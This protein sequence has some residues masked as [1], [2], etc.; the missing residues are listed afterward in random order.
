[1]RSDT[2]LR[3]AAPLRPLAVLIAMLSAS[4]ALAANN[5]DAVL[6]PVTV[7]GATPGE[8]S[9]ESSREYTVRRSPSATRLDLSLRETPQTVSVITRQ[10][11]EDFGLDSV[12][13]ALAMSSGVVV[14]KVETNRT[15]YTARGFDITNFQI[16]GV[17][18]PFVYGNVN[19]DID[20]A[21]YDR[22]DAVYGANSLMSA[23]GFPS[24]TIN[25][26]RKR[27]TPGFAAS[28]SL[29]AGS[30][31]RYRLD[32]DVSAPLN[33]AGTLRGRFVA[34]KEDANSYLD[35]YEHDKTVLYGILEADLAPSTT[36]TLGHHHQRNDA[37]SP[38]WGALPLTY[39]DGTQTDYQ[40]STSTSAD[41]A[42]WDSTIDSTFAGLTHYFGNEWVGRATVT[43]N[44]HR[45]DGA[46]FY[47]YGT[48]D[49]ATGLGL[50]S[51]PSRYELDNTQTLVDV[52][53]SG[54]FVLAGR[55]HELAVG[56]SWARSELDDISHYGRGIGTALP[57]L[58]QWDGNYPEPAFDA[59]VD[60]SDFTNTQRSAYVAAR[61][62][63]A[64]DLKLIAGARSTESENDGTSYGTSRRSSASDVSPYFGVIYDLTRN[65]SA[66]A[67]Y[68]DLFNPQ[69]Q[70]DADNVPLDP[71]EGRSKE[72]G[73]KG[74]F[75]DR[76]LN[77]SLAVFRT[78]QDKLAEV[79]GYNGPRAF[80][81][82]VDTRSKGFQID[83]AG[84]LTPRLQTSL[85][86]TQLTLKDDAGEDVR[87]YTPRK[88]LRVS[89]TYDLPF[90]DG[91]TVGASLSW[92][93]DIH[94]MAGNA[95]VRQDAYTLVN[96]MARYAI[97]KQLSVS[98]NLNNLTDEK[99]LTSLYW[100]QGYY[101]A[102]RN[103]NL[104][105][106]WKY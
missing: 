94:R 7:T 41:W 101:G 1:M 20:T 60:G 71:V 64:D 85:G 42:F 69:H 37:D 30:W 105:L 73:L 19:G 3:T 35:R 44:Q 14:E 98:A 40:R 26:V 68:T 10:Q 50:F 28:A 99:Y 12:N 46:L 53:A 54:P 29:G 52:Q 93:D 15:Y 59:A 55:K 45:N 92:Q 33:A 81:R 86:Y 11:I 67:S 62:N 104:T 18:M 48:P 103:A 76:S 17:G 25:F 102:P 74:E 79:A 96:L 95:K 63:P 77:A 27:P 78:D 82:G 8:P 66:Y 72:I 84:R 61:F 34:A 88:L 6:A 21:I 13:D 57:P 89:A 43:H 80:H 9:T 87:T 38:L 90:V 65:V 83:V 56:L 58:E 70:L 4:G 23:N 97:S 16:D 31:D 22:V 39:T 49:R 106:T 5:T 51:Y 36:F 75:F 100:A 2:P 32:A 91:L 24:A 47:M